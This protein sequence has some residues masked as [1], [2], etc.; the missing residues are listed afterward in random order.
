MEFGVIIYYL[1]CLGESLDTCFHVNWVK[2]KMV[3][4]NSHL[5]FLTFFN[6]KNKLIFKTP[7]LH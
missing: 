6:P 2:S 1:T 5:P 4:S 7:K 3:D